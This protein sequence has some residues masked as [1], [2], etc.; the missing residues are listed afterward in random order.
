M[1][2]TLSMH[3]STSDMK[4][5]DNTGIVN[6]NVEWMD[7]PYTKTAYVVSILACWFFLHVSQFFTAAECWTATNVCHGVITFILLHWIKGC[8]DD[9]T[10]GVYNG[11]TLFEQMDDGTPWTANKK[12]LMLMPALLTWISC[13]TADYQPIYLVVNIGMFVLLIIPKIPQ[14]HHVRIFGINS[15]PGIDTKIE[16]NPPSVKT[17]S[18]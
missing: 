10:Q 8:P 1:S 12:I 14:M 17:K 3:R 4:F 6:R 11:D 7:S 2:T 13:H 16:Y 15:T 5:M 18:S 9:S